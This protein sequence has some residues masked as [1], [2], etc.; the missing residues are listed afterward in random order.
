MLCI[1]FSLPILCL[2]S[3]CGVHALYSVFP[4]SIPVLCECGVGL[5]LIMVLFVASY[6]CRMHELEAACIDNLA[7]VAVKPCSH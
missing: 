3:S 5:P 4:L 7:Q 1:K 6:I 2:L